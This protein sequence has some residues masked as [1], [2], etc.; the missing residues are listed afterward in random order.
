MTLP[1]RARGG[2]PRR[3]GDGTTRAL[4]AEFTALPGSLE[5]VAELVVELTEQVRA[6]PG[7]IAFEPH[8]LESDPARWFVYEVYA[9]DDAFRAHVSGAPSAAFNAAIT[10]LVEGGGSRLTWLT[11]A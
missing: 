4:Y 10:D 2:S 5:R 6:E 8:R 9:D 3:G 1:G 7:N 11:P